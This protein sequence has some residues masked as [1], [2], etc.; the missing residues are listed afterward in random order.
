MKKLSFIA[1]MLIAASAVLSSCAN[2][3]QIAQSASAQQT[4][5]RNDFQEQIRQKEHEARL[6]E[7]E[8]E[9]E[10]RELEYQK[11]LSELKRQEVK[12]ETPCEESSYD[13]RDYFRDLGVGTHEGNNYQACRFAAVQAAKEMI[14]LRL[15]EFVQGFS[16]SYIG[17]YGGTK[18][19]NAVESVI[20]N[21]FNAIVEKMLNDADKECEQ[22]TVDHKGNI[23]VYYVVCISKRDLKKQFMDVLS[24]EE[25]DRTDYN[26]YLTQKEMDEKWEEMSRAKKA[27]GY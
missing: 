17:N 11:K 14:K 26:A 7:I 10:L 8:R 21:R 2:K 23:T 5:S 27:A 15:A 16:P 9:D 3:K 25:K 6:R 4:S 20:K 18:E 19:R 12:L 13:D 22:K 24:Q 1:V